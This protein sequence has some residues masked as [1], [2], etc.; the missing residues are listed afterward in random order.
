MVTFLYTQNHI[1]CDDGIVWEFI[2]HAG[3]TQSYYFELVIFSH[4]CKNLFL[5]LF[6]VLCTSNK[7]KY[8]YH[9]ITVLSPINFKPLS[10]TLRL[11]TPFQF[12]GHVF[13]YIWST[14]HREGCMHLSNKYLV[15]KNKLFLI[16]NK[17]ILSQ[18]FIFFIVWV[19]YN[20]QCNL[21][22]NWKQFSYRVL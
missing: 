15:M 18:F 17:L 9:K 1:C 13:I 10:D 2:I 16:S 8:K 22:I 14:E 11:Q 3:I 7:Q 4:Y 21:M 20:L 19:R 6:G 5:L 12:H